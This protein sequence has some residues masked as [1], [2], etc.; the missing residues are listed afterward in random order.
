VVPT[1]YLSG[2]SGKWCTAADSKCLMVPEFISNN[3]RGVLAAGACIHH[4]LN[5][6]EIRRFVHFSGLG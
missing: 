6:F 3:N 4:S 2:S 1:S 5:G